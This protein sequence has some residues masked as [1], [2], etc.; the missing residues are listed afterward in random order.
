MFDPF[1]IKLVSGWWM[2]W[3]LFCGFKT[4]GLATFVSQRGAR[5]SRILDEQ[6]DHR[7]VDIFDLFLLIPG[8]WMIH[9]SCEAC[10][11]TGTS[12]NLWV[13]LGEFLLFLFSVSS[14]DVYFGHLGWTTGTFGLWRSASVEPP[15]IPGGQICLSISCWFLR[16]NQFFSI[17]LG[18]VFSVET[19]SFW[20]SLHQALTSRLR[21]CWWTA[22]AWE[23]QGSAR[24]PRDGHKRRRKKAMKKP[25]A[26]CGYVIV[27]YNA[28]IMLLCCVMLC[29]V[30]SSHLMLSC[31]TML[32]SIL[33][34]E[35]L[36][37]LLTNVGAQVCSPRNFPSPCS[38][39]P[40]VTI[41]F[42]TQA[43]QRHL[44]AAKHPKLHC[45]GS[46]DA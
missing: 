36:V 43:K 37:K 14:F 3:C 2:Y 42:G 4:P 30:V 39:F 35:N 23:T 18:C 38:S 7:H 1:W 45:K 13:L 44:R 28:V 11:W 26:I 24:I 29:Y 27:C 20:C 10:N 33:P 31:C 32:Y 5:G 16:I 21:S 15:C 8:L 41:R 34:D 40:W 19:E 12:Q 25:W 22:M 17:C 9:P 46:L 6:A